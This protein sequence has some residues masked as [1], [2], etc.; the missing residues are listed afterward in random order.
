MFQNIFLNFI[1]A[2]FLFLILNFI[3]PQCIQTQLFRCLQCQ[4]TYYDQNFLIDFR[5]TKSSSDCQPKTSLTYIHKILI[6]NLPSCQN[7]ILVGYDDCYNSPILAFQAENRKLIPFSK[8]ILDFEFASG[9]HYLLK[10]DLEFVDETLFR[11]S[12]CNITLKPRNKIDTVNIY[13]KTNEF[14]FFIS[15]SFTL[16]NLNFIAK[17][18][19]IFNNNDITAR[20]NSIN[21]FCC[22]NGCDVNPPDLKNM[23]NTNNY[24]F[25]TI[26]GI[27]GEL[28]NFAYLIIKNSNFY[29]FKPIYLQYGWVQIVNLVIL[30]I[31]KFCK[32]KAPASPSEEEVLNEI[33]E[34]FKRSPDTTNK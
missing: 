4:S 32:N 14:Y 1:N 6:T 9:D 34:M 22:R 16:E 23:T 21:Q 20:Y 30:I 17:D 8:S 24:G 25:F 19:E 11:Q 29:G 12:N 33:C 7:E 3:E 31:R 27:F 18:L 5:F 28:E 13:L 15:G 26:E 2:S 10:K